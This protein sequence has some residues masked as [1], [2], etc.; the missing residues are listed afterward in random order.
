MNK[1]D[2]V[3]I[4]LVVSLAVNFLFIGIVI[5]GSLTFP[6]KASSVTTESVEKEGGAKKKVS[7]SIETEK[8]GVNDESLKYS[9]G[10]KVVL[11]TGGKN[12]YGGI[13]KS[14]KNGKVYV[15]WKVEL[16]Y[17]LKSYE[18]T[19]DISRIWEYLNIPEYIEGDFSRLEIV[20]N[21]TW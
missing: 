14:V 2:V 15:K 5:G 3:K 13:V 12:D 11:I 1:N 7:S 20:E 21:D 16:S 6:F 18:G 10:Q 4:I 17:L 8:P 19:H 9:K